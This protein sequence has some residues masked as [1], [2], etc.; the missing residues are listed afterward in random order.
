MDQAFIEFVFQVRHVQILKTQCKSL[1]LS[2]FSLF[3][4]LLLCPT[5]PGPFLHYISLPLDTVNH[6]FGMLMLETRV[7]IAVLNF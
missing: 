6:R 1:Q 5:N 3:D 7:F 4:S 2:I